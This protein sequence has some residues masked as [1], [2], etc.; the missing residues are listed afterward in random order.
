MKH[1]VERLR[2]TFHRNSYHSNPMNESNFELFHLKIVLFDSSV[3][4]SAHYRFAN[5]STEIFSK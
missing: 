4:M 1:D 3:A 2:D 5:M